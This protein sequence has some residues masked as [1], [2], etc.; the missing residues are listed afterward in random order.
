MRKLEIRMVL[1]LA[2]LVSV[3]GRAAVPVSEAELAKKLKLYASI[4][5]LSVSFKQ[6]KT[7][8]DLGMQL[9][10]EGRLKLERP[11]KVTWEITQPSP[12]LV[13]L[14]KTQIQIRSGKG[15]DAQT[16]TLKMGEASSDQPTQSLTGLIAWLNLDSK[17]LSEQYQ[18]SE[19]GKQLFH[20]EPKQK[21][22]VPFQSLDMG[23]SPDGQLKRLAIHEISGDQLEIEFG[24]PQIR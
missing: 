2:L 1:V 20:F 3:S 5:T 8:K 17:K 18:V 22:T 12:V 23:L 7:L 6:T 9:K 4:S 13:T 14:D 10:S 19:T 21:D 24:K 11:D 15:A 16:Q